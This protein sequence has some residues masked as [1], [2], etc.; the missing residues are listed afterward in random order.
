[1]L[2]STTNGAEAGPVFPARS[3]I[4]AVNAR[5][6]RRRSARED[7]APESVFTYQSLSQAAHALKRHFDLP[8]RLAASVYRE[9]RSSVTR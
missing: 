9:L 3:V 6:C 8:P 5:A 4:T 2:V 1:M 7:D